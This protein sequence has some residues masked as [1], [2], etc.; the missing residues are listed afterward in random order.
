MYRIL[1]YYACVL[2]DSARIRVP[3]HVC[4][5][6]CIH[7]CTHVCTYACMHALLHVC[8]QQVHASACKCIQVHGCACVL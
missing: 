8:M 7:V 2:H 6:A 5:Y 1:S 3:M 4:M